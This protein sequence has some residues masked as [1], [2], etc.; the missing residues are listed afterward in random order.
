MSDSTAEAEGTLEV[1]PPPRVNESADVDDR[2][3]LGDGT[4]VWHL[5]QVREG[6]VIGRRCTIGRGAYVGV[7]VAVGDHSK[8]QN[9]ALVYEPAELGHG[10]FVGPGAILSNDTRPRAVAPNGEPKTSADWTAVGVTLLDGAS[11][12]AGAVCVA[13]VRIGRWSMVAAGSVVTHDVPDHALVAGVPARQAGWVGR[14]GSR[15]EE[16]PA[17][18]VCPT[19]GERYRETGNGLALEDA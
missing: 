13:P 2:A 16:T 15:L 17:G 14:A 19:T 11:V 12:G 4:V 9:F 18:W 10:V 1:T 7:G 3:V 6:A 8:I 5:A